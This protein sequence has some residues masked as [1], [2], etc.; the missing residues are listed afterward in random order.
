MDIGLMALNGIEIRRK[1]FELQ[2]DNVRI[3]SLKA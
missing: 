3:A 1:I 2:K